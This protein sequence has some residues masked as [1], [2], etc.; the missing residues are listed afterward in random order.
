MV[1]LKIQQEG[2]R[3]FWSM[4]PL[5]RVPFW[6]SG[7]LSQSQ[8]KLALRTECRTREFL[9]WTLSKV[10]IHV[11]RLVHSESSVRMNAVL[12][13]RPASAI[14]KS[15]QAEQGELVFF[16]FFSVHDASKWSQPKAIDPILARLAFAR[17]PFV[18]PRDSRAEAVLAQ[19]LWLAQR[20]RAKRKQQWRRQH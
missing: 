1:W 17:Q 19:P 20:H 2:L 3:R 12:M 9:W 7:F 14:F 13:K 18:N 16:F 11:P 8:M 15:T 5:T 6:N 10:S 4:C